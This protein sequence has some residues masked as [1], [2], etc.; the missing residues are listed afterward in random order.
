MNGYIDCRHSSPVYSPYQVLLRDLELGEAGTLGDRDQFELSYINRS[1]YSLVNRHH[2]LST[3]STIQ[4]GSR[5]CLP[6]R[7]HVHRIRPGSKSWSWQRIETSWLDSA[8]TNFIR[9]FVN[10]LFSREIPDFLDVVQSGH[11]E[12]NEE[13]GGVC[14]EW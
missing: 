10:A 8:Q 12:E 1:K 13:W 14:G 4:Y 11:G 5:S 7:V 9:F 2:S 3:P 6:Q